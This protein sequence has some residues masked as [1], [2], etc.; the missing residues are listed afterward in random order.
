MG[1]ERAQVLRRKGRNPCE[2]EQGSAASC[3]HDSYADNYTTSHRSHKNRC[4]GGK[5]RGASSRCRGL[6]LPLP[7]PLGWRR[8]VL[9]FKAESGRAQVA[10]QIPPT[11]KSGRL[12]CCSGASLVCLSIVSLLFLYCSS[13]LPLVLASS[14]ASNSASTF[15]VAAVSFIA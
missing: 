7:Q 2:L 5:R 14:T 13:I 6:L 1:W 15:P 3:L 12:A 10:R 8:L 11:A 4:A 9:S